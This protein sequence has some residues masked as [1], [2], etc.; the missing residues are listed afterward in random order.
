MKLY[1]LQPTHDPQC[2]ELLSLYVKPV[3]E[4]SCRTCNYKGHFPMDLLLEWEPGSDSIPDFLSAGARVVTRDDIILDL[5]SRFGGIKR[6]P[7][8]FHDHPNLYKPAKI[9]KRTKPCVWLPYQGPPLSELTATRQVPIHTSS[10]VK[11]QKRCSA[12]NRP[13][14]KAFENI[15]EKDCRMHTLRVP[16]KGLFFSR[17]DIGDDSFFNPA[18]TGLLLCTETAAGFLNNQNYSGLDLLEVGDMID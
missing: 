14:F 16:E 9:T 8:R 10:T 7:L 5:M 2:A 3:V 6:R 13:T 12:C 15:E 18:Y 4:P 1:K 17:A 11:I